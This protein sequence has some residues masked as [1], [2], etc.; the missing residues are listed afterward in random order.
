MYSI[1]ST[2]YERAGALKFQARRAQ[3]PNQFIGNQVHLCLR[4]SQLLNLSHHDCFIKPM[5]PVTISQVSIIRPVS[6]SS[7]A[8]KRAREYLLKSEARWGMWAKH[9]LHNLLQNSLPICTA[10]TVRL[11]MLWS[12]HRVYGTCCILSLDRLASERV[13]IRPQTRA[14]IKVPSQ[15]GAVATTPAWKSNP[16]TFETAETARPI[17]ISAPSSRHPLHY[18]ESLG[19][20]ASLSSQFESNHRAS[21]IGRILPHGSCWNGKETD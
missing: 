7:A 18:P 11:F 2:A 20:L 8:H 9:L 15:T 5:E 10:P 4:L 21:S 17:T 6:V 16:P 12:L 1:S 13:F 19:H 14:S 3:W